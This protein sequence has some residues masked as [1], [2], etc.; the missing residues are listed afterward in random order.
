M[1]V[2]G[3]HYYY[4]CSYRNHQQCL[5]AAPNSDWPTLRWTRTNSTNVG[6]YLHLPIHRIHWRESATSPSAGNC[7][8]TRVLLHWKQSSYVADCSDYSNCCC[9]LT[10]MWRSHWKQL[11]VLR[12]YTFDCW[13]RLRWHWCWHRATCKWWIHWELEIYPQ[14]TYSWCEISGVWWFPGE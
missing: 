14:S 3:S 6:L 9:W 10:G 5:L 1:A 11:L 8:W 12:Y 4:S 7:C 13:L 2:T